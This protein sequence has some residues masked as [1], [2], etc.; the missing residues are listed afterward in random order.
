MITNFKKRL[1]K[2]EASPKLYTFWH[3]EYDVA[4]NKYVPVSY[5][6]R[7]S[8]PVSD[9]F[10]GGYAAACHMSSLFNNPAPNR[11]IEDFL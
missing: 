3:W 10:D 1:A 4:E 9:N 2:L 5:Q 11:C 8:G 6:L 7:P